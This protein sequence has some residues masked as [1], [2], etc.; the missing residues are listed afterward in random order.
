M[1]FKQMKAGFGK[2]F[3]PNRIFVLFVFLVLAYGLMS[4][5]ESKSWS[6]LDLMT[7]MNTPGSPPGASPPISPPANPLVPPVQ[8]PAAAPDSSYTQATVANP[9]DL[10]PTTNNQWAALNPAISNQGIQTPDLLQAGSLIG[11]DT[12]GQT[13]RNANL[14][15]RSDPI[16]PVTQV[17]PWM[18]S[19][20]E[21]DMMRA[22][23]EINR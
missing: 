10:L 15:L 22:P 17:S 9:S 8:N 2:F 13:L 16:I 6:N 20:I 4:Y 5:S 3:S 23:F 1:V 7:T 19:T 12:V 11:L 18:Q 14:Q 21:P